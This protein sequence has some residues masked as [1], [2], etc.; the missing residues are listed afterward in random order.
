MTYAPEIEPLASQE[1]NTTSNVLAIAGFVLVVLVVL[2]GSVNIVTT[3]SAWLSSLLNASGYGISI[4]APATATDHTSF[5]LSWTHTQSSDGSYTML[6]R[7]E[8][9]VRLQTPN[10]AGMHNDIPCGATFMLGDTTSITLMPLMST[11][12]P[13]VDLPISIFFVPNASGTP[14]LGI[15]VVRVVGQTNNSIQIS[16]APSTVSSAYSFAQAPSHASTVNTYA[17]NTLPDLSVHIVSAST[18]TSGMTSVVFDIANDGSAPS[19]S[20]YFTASIPTASSY[21]YTSPMQ[22]SLDPR[23]HVVNTLRFSRGYVGS[24]DVF[25]VFVDPNN[26]IR[27]SNKDNNTAS[28]VLDSSAAYPVSQTYPPFPYQYQVN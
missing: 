21:T 20:Y 28:Q 18:D 12:S 1:R 6:Y 25:S 5:T 10:V 14:A 7:C 15:T 4:S 19:G 23:A 13:V 9:G 17:T 24:Q 2:F 3:S 8:S 22:Q 11:T 16:D 27:E 26:V